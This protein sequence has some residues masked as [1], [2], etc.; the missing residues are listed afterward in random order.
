DRGMSSS[1]Q[2]IAILGAGAGIGAELARRLAAPGRRLILHTGSRATALEAVAQASAAAGAETVSFLGD[3]ADER[4]MDGLIGAFR[5][6]EPLDA[7]VFAA[8]Y[9]R[10]SSCADTSEKDLAD[11]FSAMP[12]AF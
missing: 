2:H 11:A 6:A 4:T 1:L 9:A 7:L 10:R 3:L 5:S 12:I 8:G